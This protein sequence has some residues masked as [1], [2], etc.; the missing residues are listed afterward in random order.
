MSERLVIIFLSESE[1]KP[2]I[3]FTK[4]QETQKNQIKKPLH[5]LESNVQ[6]KEKE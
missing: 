1:T 6:T 3:C 2:K 5:K 4:W